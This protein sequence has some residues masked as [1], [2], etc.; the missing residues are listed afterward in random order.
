M[1]WEVR[2]LGTQT[3]VVHQQRSLRVC[4]TTLTNIQRTLENALTCAGRIEKKTGQT[5]IT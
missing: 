3:H 4:Q 1:T 2:S 5:F